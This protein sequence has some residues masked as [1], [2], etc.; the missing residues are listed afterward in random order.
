MA[1]INPDDTF[2]KI[3]NRVETLHQQI[4]DIRDEHKGKDTDSR[5]VNLNNVTMAT[6]A[7]MATLKLWH[8]ATNGG[9]GTLAKALGLAKPEYITPVSKDHLR[10]SRLF[11]LLE[12]QFQIETLFR[13]IL[14][15]LGKP[16]NKQGFYTVCKDLLA[17]VGSTNPTTKLGVLNVAALMRNSMHSNGMHHGRDG[18]NTITTINGV[19]FRFEHNQPVSCGSWYHIVVALMASFEIIEEVLKSQSVSSLKEIPDAYAEEVS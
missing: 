2:E 17:A 8:W 14:L 7:A 12:S 16:A 19:E 13:N 9:E 4:C 18:A 10:S 6:N 11:L 5:C 3:A 15:A 1:F